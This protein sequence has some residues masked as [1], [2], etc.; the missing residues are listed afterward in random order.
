MHNKLERII[1]EKKRE[2]AALYHL[3]ESNA[4]HPIVS[5]L[6]LLAKPMSHHY[7]KQALNATTSLAVIAEIKRRSPS[8][9]NLATIAQPVELAKKYISGGAKAIS[10]L[11]DETFFGGHLND[12]HQVTDTFKPNVAPVLRKD[13]II[14]KIQIAEAYVANASAILLIVAVVKN[15]LKELLDYAHAIG[16]DVLVEVHDMAELQLAIDCHA[17]IIGINN[18]NLKTF[19]VDTACAERLIKHIPKHIITVAESGILTHAQARRY[20]EAGFNAVLIGE[21]LVTS[22]DPEQFIRACTNG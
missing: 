17:E 9:G 10:I 2:V 12:L 20:H 15:K 6:Q 3:I 22:K 16:L 8:K 14:D 4:A 1:E 21:A 7:F 18:R 11:T 5:C 19:V 13:F